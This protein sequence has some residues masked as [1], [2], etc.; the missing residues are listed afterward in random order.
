MSIIRATTAIGTAGVPAVAGTVY[1]A[2]AELRAA[3]AT[4]NGRINIAWYNAGGTFLSRNQGSVVSIPNGGPWTQ[5]NVSSITAP[6]NTA[7][8][9]VEIEFDGNNGEIF[10]ADKIILATGANPAWGPGGFSGDAGFILER[11]ADG[12]E[13]WEY[14]V[15]ATQEDPAP[16]DGGGVS[17]ATI[18]DRYTPLRT[19]VRYRGYVQTGTTNKVTS[20]SATSSDS[21]NY[22]TEWWMRCLD[23]AECDTAIPVTSHMR[24][25]GAG[26]VGT[27]F[28]PEGRD[29]PVVVHGRR[30]SGSRFSLEILSKS[31]ADYEDV[32]FI[33]GEKETLI[34]QDV[35]GHVWYLK[36]TGEVTAEQIRAAPTSDELSPVRHL[37]QLKC[38]VT[39]VAH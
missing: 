17:Q 14:V 29:K 23:T 3:T 31:K 15:G 34:V 4:R 22:A 6:A 33:L 24:S 32:M 38:E 20:S 18:V 25:F 10:Y 39:E 9:A 35:L 1:S 27:A 8:A 37:Y 16:D 26:M 28:E 19:Q 30:P 5:V 36:V 7:F 21:V 13:T 11:S 12:G 2:A